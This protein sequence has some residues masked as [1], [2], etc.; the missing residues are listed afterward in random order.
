M[1]QTQLAQEEREYQEWMARNRLTDPLPETRDT[2]QIPAFEPAPIDPSMLNQPGREATDALP[3]VV[4]TVVGAGTGYGAYK[5]LQNLLKPA[6]APAPVTPTPSPIVNAAGQP[7]ASSTP[8]QAP[9]M[10]QRGADMAR[11][12]QK[13]AANRVQAAAPYIARVAG[14]AAAA[15]LPGNMNQ[16]YPFPQEGAL[17]G[18][19]INPATG[20]PWTAAEL[21]QYNAQMR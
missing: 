2:T 8:A 13:I 6:P 4:G 17:R 1:D 9:N 14:G 16:D 12:M 10:L 3:Y 20:R 5:G 19:E 15:L 21:Q 11:Q 18:Q 7:F